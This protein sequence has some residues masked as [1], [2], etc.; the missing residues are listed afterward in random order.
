VN[1]PV[2]GF[3]ST[4]AALG[5]ADI[6]DVTLTQSLPANESP[7]QALLWAEAYS[8]AAVSSAWFEVKSPSKDLTIDTT[9]ATFQRTVD[10]PKTAMTLVGGKWQAEATFTEP[11]TY[12]IF[13]FTK[14]TNSE[15]SEMKRSV[16]YKDWSAN[17]QPN[18]FDLV[19]PS[20]TD[21]A[22]HTE[23]VLVW[24]ETT[25][26]DSDSLTYTVQIA[27][28]DQFASIKYQQEELVTGIHARS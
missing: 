21:T 3:G 13:Y 25:D 14:S 28:D 24:N 10:N 1:G 19:S 17:Q 18:A 2:V 15:I 20:P 5:P 7:T 12:E 27:T 23:L 4:N 16:V 22:P 11:G 6:K 9:T 8:N 26:P